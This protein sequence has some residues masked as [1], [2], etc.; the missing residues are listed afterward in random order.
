MRDNKAVGLFFAAAD[1]ERARQ[2]LE[3]EPIRSAVKL[4][5]RPPAEPLERAYLLALRYRLYDEVAAGQTALDLLR[6]S[7]FFRDTSVDLPAIKRA[8]GWLS[9]LALL[10]AEADLL[11]ALEAKMLAFATVET[12]ADPL[13]EL[14]LGALLLAA[15]RL[16]ANEANFQRAVAIYRQAVDQRIHPEGYLKGIVDRD[17]A[18]RT[19]ADQ[20]AGTC[21]LVLLA[22]L[23]EPAGLDLWSY[24]NRAVSV[25]T[26]ASY[27]FYYYFY[28]ENWRWGPGLTR[29]R[30]LALMRREGAFME[31]LNRRH[32][33][34]DIDA[35]FAEQRPLFCVYGGGLTTLT[36]GLAPPKKQRWRFW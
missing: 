6:A 36:H 2:N 17:D 18:E 8:L 16:Q 32:K 34:H 29:E 7:D 4:L 20:L 30:T 15:A 11:A 33:L 35:L 28:P 12:A 27:T 13:R 19:Y 25:K 1:L 5:E 22:E 26:A 23:A 14:W 3:R 9:V 24:S 10:E 31:M 21:A